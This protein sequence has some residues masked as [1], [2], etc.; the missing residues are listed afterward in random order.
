MADDGKGSSI[1][2]PS[3]LISYSDG[4]LVKDYFQQLRQNRTK[5]QEHL[6]PE[7]YLH[8]PRKGHQVIM[9]AKIDF[10]IGEMKKNKNEKINVDIWYSTL[11]EL[12]ESRID[13][14]KLAK[15]QDIFKD[16]VIFH[17]RTYVYGC[18]WCD[19]KTKD[20]NCIFNGKYCPFVPDDVDKNVIRPRELLD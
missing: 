14:D 18:L 1:R 19:Q 8:S 13:F 10:G 3:F 2:I 5:E 12:Q 6:T 11:Y 7:G 4:K 17:P 15:M 20:K 9:Q 16:K